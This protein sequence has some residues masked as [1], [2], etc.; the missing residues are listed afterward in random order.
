MRISALARRL[1]NYSLYVGALIDGDSR[2]ACSLVALT[3]KL[4]FIVYTCVYLPFILAYGLPEQLLTDKGTEWS[5]CAFV[6]YL[7][8]CNARGG[9]AARGA[10]AAHRYVTS[11]RNVRAEPPS[12]A[13]AFCMPMLTL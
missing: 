9:A 2:L 3:C 12:S 5:I 11:T 6:Q 1:Q 4:P 7:I 8:A 13:R 10:R